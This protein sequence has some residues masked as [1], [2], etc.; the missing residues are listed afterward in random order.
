MF[1]FLYKTLLIAL[2]SGS[3]TTMNFAA[4][5]AD[6]SVP[7]TKSADNG[8]TRDSNGV[9]KKTETAKLDAVGESD[10]LS[11]VTMLVI[12]VIGAR[13]AFN[14]TPITTD[15]MIAAAG[16]AAF[17]AGE[18]LS[19][20]NAKKVV[21]E[22]QA[23]ITKSSDG[24]NDQAQ[25]DRLEDLKKSYE[26]MKKSLGTKKMLQ[27]AAAAAF[28]GAAALAVYY[29]FKEESMNAACEGAVKT[30]QG[31]LKT[32]I[33]TGKAAAVTVP[34][35]TKLVQEGL[36]CTTCEIE[37]ATYLATFK[38]KVVN[39]EVPGASLAKAVQENSMSAILAKP[40]CAAS[41]GISAKMIAMGVDSACKPALSLSKMLH[42][43]GTP[44]KTSNS[45]GSKLLNRILFGGDRAIASNIEINQSLKP[46]SF[47]DSAT[48][49]IFPKAE[50]S[51]MSLLGLGV[52]AAAS[53][54][55]LKG[56]L[57]TAI[58]TMMYV[59]LN[60]GIIFGVLAGLAFMA[61]KSSQSQ[62]DAIEKNIEK[63][64]RI[65][66]D[67]GALEKGVKTGTISEQQIQMAPLNK[68]LNASVPLSSGTTNKTDCIVSSGNG[69][70]ASLS[71]TVS[72]M[73]GYSGLPDSFKSIASQSA[74]L[75]DGLSG[76]SSISGT[77]L[78][79]AASLAG[80]QKAI[81]NLLAKSQRKLNERLTA[82]GKAN[83]DFNKEQKGLLRRMNAAT[84][85]GLASK[86]SSAGSFLSS[87]GSTPISNAE[88][89]VAAVP[90]SG[91]ASL[92][93]GGLGSGGSGSFSAPGKK[94]FELDF[95]DAAGD[96]AL[97][98]GAEAGKEE[99]FDI[100]TND[101]NTDSG[102][103]IFE[104]ISNRYI[105]SGYP[106]LLDEIPVKN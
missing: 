27:T 68:N 62:I 34:V 85:R 104:L 38:T 18:V 82:S 30:A 96:P 5:A 23:E 98:A 78:G 84:S 56:T 54:W 3:L 86:G 90:Y 88:A 87:V 45:D 58:D 6:S 55:L 105:K 13:M 93:S 65:L 94:D 8:L 39:G 79:D 28:A 99:K 24:K 46:Q 75:G 40:N 76:A 11:S 25:I 36:A 71:E 64:D 103:S 100:G 37:L 66:K 15:V 16:A 69:N 106:K 14:Y 33:A 95:K 19:T 60:R 67:L 2:M 97:A 49:F 47:L 73:P 89:A 12:G 29:S 7:M 9:L 48:N 57:G 53:F 4:Y 74:K 42:V 77:T 81:A 50:A 35:G 91:K 92:G 43:S 21:G 1:Q 10:M 32:C 44:D 61:S 83:V 70:C 52:G 20:M 51:M 72:S 63:I 59:P 17:I 102:E 41:T 22:M 101:I 31:G 80:K 26:E